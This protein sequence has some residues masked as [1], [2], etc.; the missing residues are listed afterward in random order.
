VID[1]SNLTGEARA[2]Y[3]SQTKA[4]GFSVTG[5]YFKSVLQ[6]SIERNKQRSGKVLIPDKG[7]LALIESW[8]CQ[9][10][11]TALTDYFMSKSAMTAKLM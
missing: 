9:A 3:I 4:A 8:N 7:I 5:Y 1:N 10:W 11:T 2:G 6:D